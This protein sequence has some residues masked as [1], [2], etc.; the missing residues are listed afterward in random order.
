[1]YPVDSESEDEDDFDYAGRPRE[2]VRRGSEGYE[3]KPID[4][5][6]LLRQYI[7]DRTAAPGRYH[8][9]VPDPPSDVENGTD[10]DRVPSA[11]KMARWQEASA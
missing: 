10:D 5:E 11:E 6:G 4:R 8:L 1:M 2:F 7:E 3:V 9:Y